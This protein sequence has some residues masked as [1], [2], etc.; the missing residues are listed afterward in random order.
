MELSRLELVVLRCGKMQEA[1]LG[2]RITDQTQFVPT[3]VTQTWPDSPYATLFLVPS[4]SADAEGENA[5]DPTLPDKSG[6]L[7]TK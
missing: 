4:P 7:G 5:G 1:R 6:E 3:R 2:L